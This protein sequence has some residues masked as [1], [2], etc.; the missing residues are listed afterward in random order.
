MDNVFET[1]FDISQCGH[2]WNIASAHL[3]TLGKLLLLL[4]D[5]AQ[6]EVN[7]VGFLKVG[8]HSHDLGEGLLGMLERPI[9]IVENTDAVPQLGL[10]GVRKVVES[11]LVSTICVLEI[12]HHQLTVSQIAPYLTIRRLNLEDLSQI[13][14][15]FWV[16]LLSAQCARDGAQH[17]NRPVVVSESLLIRVECVYEVTGKLVHVS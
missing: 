17:R 11:L 8:L 16:L 14:H 2:V 5:D 13:V 10:L 12:V 9:A 1:L 7:F 3:K 4:V 6:P 15:S